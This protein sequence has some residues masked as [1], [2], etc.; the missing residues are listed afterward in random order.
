MTEK[1]YKLTISNLEIT[2]KENPVLADISKA[3]K[4]IFLDANMALDYSKEQN[5]KLNVDFIDIAKSLEFA[6]LLEDSEDF[7]LKLFRELEDSQLIKITDKN[8]NNITFY[9]KKRI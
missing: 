7:I 6:E 1:T 9:I 4:K 3:A 2:E 5:K 8:K